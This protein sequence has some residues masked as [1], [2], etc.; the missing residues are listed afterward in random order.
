MA[1]AGGG[2]E[3]H[4]KAPDV[5]SF[6]CLRSV[7]SREGMETCM[8]LPKLPDVARAEA[9]KGS[10]GRDANESGRGMEILQRNT[11]WLKPCSVLAPLLPQLRASWEGRKQWALSSAGA[12]G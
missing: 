10:F 4:G 2:G 3:A 8:V 12:L 9:S 6:A 5:V 11:L 7:S 1:R